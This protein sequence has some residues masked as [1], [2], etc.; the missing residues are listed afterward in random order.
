MKF[1][2]FILIVLGL[3]SV[4]G[5]LI[6]QNLEAEYYLTAYESMGEA[7][8]KLGFDHVYTSTWYGVIT[9]FLCLSLFFCVVVR[10]RPLITKLKNEGFKNSLEKLGSWILHFGLILTI[11]FF[12]V[13][14]ATAYTYSF[15]NVEDTINEIEDTGLSFQIDSFD[16]ELYPDDTVKTYKTV[17]KV[18]DENGEILKSGE[19]LVNQPMNVNG[20]QISQLSFG[21]VTDCKI[22]KDGEEIGTAPLFKNEYVAA[23]K[24]LF[25]VYMKDLY[26]NLE[27]REDGVYNASKKMENPYVDYAVVF[28]GTLVKQGLEKVD[29]KISVGHYDIE[30]IN[31]RHYTVLDVRKDKF[32]KFTAVGAFMVMGGSFLCF[33]PNIKKEEEDVN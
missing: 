18:L 21:L 23:D 13:G 26:P 33:L 17:G 19:I 20:Y 24:G 9:L 2:I 5:T 6:P 25:L 22:Y 32:A 28:G 30:F 14:N 11:I 4:I 12:T 7:I 29:K 27:I 8:V 15:H 1:A 3:A 16:I 10:I 31:P